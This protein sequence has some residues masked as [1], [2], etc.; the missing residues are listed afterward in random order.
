MNQKQHIFFAYACVNV[1]KAYYRKMC[2][3]LNKIIKTH[4]FGKK[5]LNKEYDYKLRIKS[6]DL[7]LY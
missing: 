7:I 1:K 6:L 3:F 2:L 4:I 5:P